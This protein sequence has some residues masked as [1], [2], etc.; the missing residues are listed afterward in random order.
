M[1]VFTIILSFSSSFV[2]SNLF[3][4]N[5]CVLKLV[6]IKCLYSPLFSP[7]PHRVC[8][9]TC[10]NTMFVFTIILSFFS[11]FVFSN[12]FQYNVCIHHYSF[13]F[14]IVCVLKL[15]F[16]NRPLLRILFFIF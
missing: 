12:L 8:S 5:V 3:Q 13:L 4:Y 7:F 16:A 2:F 11:S 9:P 6:P 14:L 10:S 1:F 15:N